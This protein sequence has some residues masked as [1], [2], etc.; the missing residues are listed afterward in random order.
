MRPIRSGLV[1]TK[2]VSGHSGL[3]SPSLGKNVGSMLRPMRE[4]FTAG[5]QGGADDLVREEPTLGSPKLRRLTTPRP[6]R[7]PSRVDE[8]HSFE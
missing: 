3:A 5:D 2:R 7:K 6:R 4:I 1:G 8:Y